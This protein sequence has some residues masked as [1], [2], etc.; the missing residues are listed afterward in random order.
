MKRLVIPILIFIFAVIV[1]H[2]FT[3][4]AAPA[5]IMKKAMQTM[6]AR[7]LP[8]HKFVLG[9][10]VTPQTQTVVRPAPDLVY[11]ICLFDFSV[12]N[13]PLEIRA[14]FWADYGS[15]SFFD[16]RTNNFATVR[17]GVDGQNTDAKIYLI[18]K[19]INKP[20]GGEVGSAQIITSPS[21]RGLILIRRLAPSAEKYQQVQD[22]AKAD[23][24]QPLV[25]Q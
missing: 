24:C 22:V 9:G 20:M 14:G 1:G 25:D 6:Q 2:V 18:T 5:I 21:E 8:L 4:K 15:V 13:R 3:L 7:G 17:V 10:R 19:D 11:S 23:L 12:T 16:A